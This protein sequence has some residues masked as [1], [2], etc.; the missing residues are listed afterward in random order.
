VQPARAAD[1]QKFLRQQTYESM[2]EMDTPELIEIW[3]EADHEEWTDLA[4]EVIQQIL[5]ERIGE[6]PAQDPVEL[7]PDDQQLE[8][9]GAVPAPQVELEFDPARK[10]ALPF[11]ASFNLIALH[12]PD[13]GKT[14]SEED[15]VCPHCGVDLEAPLDETQLQALAAGYLEK[16]QS[17]FDFGRD[18]KSALADCD[19][20]L[21]YTPNSARVHN[22][23]GLILDA[24][25]KTALAVRA[26]REAVRLDPA[27]AGA[28][29]NLRDAEA[30]LSSRKI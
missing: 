14:I 10:D 7:D 19:L 5:L 29:D 24:L 30:E 18:Y 21:E 12:C 26:Y 1:I 16:A 22:L 20:A 6:V 13:C 3:Q 11:N 9:V 23:R 15:R 28:R 2:D 4:F 25:G 17:S 8:Q 27:L